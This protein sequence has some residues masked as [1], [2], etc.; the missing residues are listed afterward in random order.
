M[1]YLIGGPPRMGKSTLA[2]KLLKEQTIPYVSTDGL[3]VMLK[4]MGEPSFYSPEKAARLYPVLETFI[5]RMLKVCPDYTIEGDAFSPHHVDALRENHE[6][7]AIFFTM[8]QVSKDDIIQ[9]A[10]YDNW[11]SSDTESQLDDLVNRI[12]D[13]SKIIQEECLRLDIP[14]FD[15]SNNYE[16]TFE[17]AYRALTSKF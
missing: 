11:A 3:T 4:P 10:K 6:L 9:Y 16:K 13:A 7:R 12:T 8:S 5:S 14:C 15:L 2:Q 1:L 17:L